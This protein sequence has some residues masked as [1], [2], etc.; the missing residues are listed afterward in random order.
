MSSSLA[1][2]TPPQSS[3][4]DDDTTVIVVVFVSFG[5]IFGIVFCLFALWWFIKKRRQRMVQETEIVDI[6]KHVKMQE[7]IVEG[8]HGPEKVVLSVEED[9]KIDDEIRRNE[10]ELGNKNMGATTEE[11]N[12]GALEAGQSSNH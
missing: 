6:N 5:C 7:A 9:V 10:I 4:D 2:Y 1:G 11:I 8:P 12:L 3:P